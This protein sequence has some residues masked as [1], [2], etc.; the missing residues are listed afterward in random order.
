[1]NNG[2]FASNGSIYGRLKLLQSNGRILHVHKSH[3]IIRCSHIFKDALIWS[4]SNFPSF[5]YI[6][7]ILPSFI[8]FI[9]LNLWHRTLWARCCASL[10]TRRNTNRCNLLQLI[11]HAEDPSWP[12]QGE[13]VCVC[14]YIECL[15]LSKK[16]I[17]FDEN[18]TYWCQFANNHFY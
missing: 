1:M 4:I 15:W 6:I 18:D 5:F 16:K 11:Y 14:E 10:Y 3:I 2:P 12:N 17:H 8:H 7:C 9:S 13:C